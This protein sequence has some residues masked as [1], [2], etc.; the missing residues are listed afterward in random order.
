MSVRGAWLGGSEGGWLGDEH[1]YQLGETPTAPTVSTTPARA[2]HLGGDHGGQLGG[3]HGY[4]LS[5]A[6]PEPVSSAFADD[7]LSIVLEGPTGGQRALAT[8]DRG[9]GLLSV[10]VTLETRTV[11]DWQVVVPYAPAL[12]RW[13][14]ATM[15]LGFDGERI[16][17]G[18][19]KTVSTPD[20]ESETTLSGAGPLDALRRGDISV[21][22]R[23]VYADT[24]ADRVLADHIPDATPLQH[25]VTTPAA[26]R[27]TVIEGQEFSGSPLSVLAEICDHGNLT[28]TVDHRERDPVMEV[29]VPGIHAARP[30][31]WRTLDYDRKF[32]I[33]DYANRV[34]V[35]GA[36]KN[37]GS[38]EN[39]RGVAEADEE[40]QQITNGQPITRRVET[41]LPT[42]RDCR[43]RAGS[44]LESA[45]GE[46]T[47][48]ASATTTPALVSVP[49]GYYYRLPELE[50]EGITDDGAVF[51]GLGQTSYTESAG[52]AQTTLDFDTPD[53]V[54]QALRDAVDAGQ[55]PSLSYRNPTTGERPT[56][57]A[58]W[59][60]GAWG[61]GVW[62]DFREVF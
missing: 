32:S 49:P 11:A 19:L 50:G 8:A 33:E 13:A 45:L 20:D 44:E 58:E 43:A 21:R 54:T 25:R 29:F 47:L 6:G 38:G 59:G 52:E 17:R 2:A 57:A 55:R 24:A 16:F 46:R 26:G 51:L 53:A 40:I 15:H 30:G 56:V 37:D 31:P 61:D 1:G 62:G 60:D 36:P 42:D 5:T 39:F 48:S 9:Y 18:R 28:W 22:F 23:N 4:Q 7:G 3:V 12:E 34:V 14:F 10:D 35:V 41:N 27:R